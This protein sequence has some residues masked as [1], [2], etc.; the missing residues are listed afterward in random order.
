VHD[1]QVDGVFAAMNTV[2]PYQDKAA[3]EAIESLSDE[4]KFR[5][6]YQHFDRAA[7][8]VRHRV[9][10]RLMAEQGIAARSKVRV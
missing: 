6:R 3:L 10:R 9:E 5:E 8:D 1:E 7:L 4:V 2:I